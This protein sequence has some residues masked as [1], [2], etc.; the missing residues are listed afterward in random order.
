MKLLLDTNV[1][2]W[3]LLDELEIQKRARQSLNQN[4][5]TAFVSVVSLWEIAIKQSTGKLK[6]PGQASA[7][8][9][10]AVEDSNIEILPLAPAHATGVSDLPWHHRDPYDRLIIVQA[11]MEKMTVITR[12]RHFHL[13]GI[14]VLDA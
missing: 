1:L 8:L 2:L 10:P 4:D 6:L 7:W 12:D 13:Y 9:T 14:A 3:V 5:S 11:Q